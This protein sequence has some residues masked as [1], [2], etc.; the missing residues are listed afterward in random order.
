MVQ[1]PIKYVSDVDYQATD[2]CVKHVLKQ[3]NINYRALIQI[4]DI[5]KI[6]KRKEN[7]LLYPL[8]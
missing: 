6:T 3:K 8:K 1:N 4:K 7:D 2:I 5:I